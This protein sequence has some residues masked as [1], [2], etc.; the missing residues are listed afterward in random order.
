VALL[1]TGGMT[2]DMFTFTPAEKE[3]TARFA[4]GVVKGAD[5]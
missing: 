2:C 1:R 5:C 3:K 4:A